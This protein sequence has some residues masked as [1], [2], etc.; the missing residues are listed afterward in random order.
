MRATRGYLP[1]MGNVNVIL[2]PSEKSVVF[3]LI[4]ADCKAVI[5]EKLPSIRAAYCQAGA[6]SQHEC[7][8]KVL[9]A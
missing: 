4:C 2:Q 7:E 8:V 3:D 9:A 6:I 1:S 5:S